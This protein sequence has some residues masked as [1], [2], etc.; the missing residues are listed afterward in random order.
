ME[1]PATNGGHA[2]NDQYSPR[3]IGNVARAPIIALATITDP[4][5]AAPCYFAAEVVNAHR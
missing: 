2:L 1:P 4:A 3:V 5:R